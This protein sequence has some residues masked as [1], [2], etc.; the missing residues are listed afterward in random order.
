M[1]TFI[2]LVGLMLSSTLSQAGS[3]SGTVTGPD[4][5]TP[6][7]NIY[8]IAYQRIDDGDGGNWIFAQVTTTNLEGSYS[9]GGLA[10]GIYQV[11]FYGTSDYVGEYY[12]NATMLGAGTDIPV[13]A[14]TTVS[15][16]NASLATASRITGT[17][18][19][20]DDSTPLENINVMAYQW[21][22]DGAGGGWSPVDA[23]S[24][25]ADGSYVL[26][27][28]AAGTYRVQFSHGS[29]NY[30]TECYNNAPNLDAAT[31]IVVN[32]ASTANDINA[33]LA[34]AE[35]NGYESWALLD[36]LPAN[37]R[38][39]HD[40]NGP[41]QLPNLLCYG[42]GIDPLQATPSDLPSAVKFDPGAGRAFFRYRR[43]TV[44]TGVSLH[45]WISTDLSSWS[46]APILGASLVETGDTW[47]V[48]E[49]EVELTP[50]Q[51]VFFKVGATQ[52]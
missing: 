19:G 5:T 21:I 45:P 41:L 24:T 33:S 48:M 2:F 6:L 25:A 14:A 31:D 17:V 47:Q 35:S 13:A 39:A 8:V 23:S 34:L 18:T 32:D 11:H 3:I 30:V 27:G 29:G 7:E 40:R 4:E 50:G 51:P 16:I 44:A 43:S 12:D 36:T 22:D 9:L 37:K 20:P 46:D 42:M 1:K 49:I 15:G 28:L 10:G 52:P 38:G 26:G